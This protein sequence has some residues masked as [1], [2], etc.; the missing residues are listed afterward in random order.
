MKVWPIDPLVPRSSR[1][2]VPE[3]LNLCWLWKRACPASLP[4]ADDTTK[5]RGSSRS[6]GYYQP[7]E[8][9]LY[10]N[11]VW[12]WVIRS[13]LLRPFQAMKWVHRLDSSGL[14]HAAASDI[15]RL[16]R[17]LAWMQ[18]SSRWSIQEPLGAR[19]LDHRDNWLVAAKRS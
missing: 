12:V 8:T 5:L 19:S 7:L 15:V 3:K 14:R 11:N 1:L 6:P 4:I 18:S 13:Q 17:E 10:S 2:E 16:Q 9:A